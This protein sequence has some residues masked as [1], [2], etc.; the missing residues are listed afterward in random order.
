VFARTVATPGSVA[1][2]ESVI[3]YPSARA[4]TVD[5]ALDARS[6]TAR[7]K[8]GTLGFI[9]PGGTTAK[10]TTAYQTAKFPKIGGGAYYESSGVPGTADTN[11]AVTFVSG[12]YIVRLGTFGG[13]NP[14]TITDLKTIAPRALKRLPIPTPIP[15]T[16]TTL[17]K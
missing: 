13:T 12:P 7:L 15:P 16:T 9:P 3:S 17:A 10:G 5:F 2:I 8:C 4:A 1:L 6:H 11:A 14:V